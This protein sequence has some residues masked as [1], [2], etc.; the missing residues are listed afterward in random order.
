MVTEAAEYLTSAQDHLTRSTIW[1][2]TL[3]QC[4]FRG[5]I[6][7]YAEFSRWH[8]NASITLKP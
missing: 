3:A 2:R 7:S 4:S 6:G 1:R 5:R 8:S